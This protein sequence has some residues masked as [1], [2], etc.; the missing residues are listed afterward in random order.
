MNP[1]PD[2][3]WNPKQMTNTD[4]SQAISLIESARR[5]L[6]TTHIRPD[7]D[8]VGSIAALKTIIEQAAGQKQNDCV[9]QLL[10][11]S[12]PSDNYM[13]LLPDETWFLGEHITQEQINAG[14][15]ARFDLIIIAD[16]CAARQLQGL[17]NYLTQR[18]KNARETDASILVIDH[19]LSG[20]AIG[21]CQLVDTDA[22]A[23][24]EIIYRL[25]RRAD[26][27]LNESAASALLAAIGTDTGW[28]QF[29]NS[30]AQAFKIAG[31]LLEAGAKADRIYQKLYQNDPPEKL[32]LLAMTLQTLELYCDGRLAVMQITREML[33]KS[34]A[35]RS[36]IE[37]IVNEPQNIASVIAV[38]LLVAQDDGSTRGSLRSK[39]KVDVN[40]VARQFGGG[41]HARAAGLTIQ[42]PL[43]IARKRIIDA[44]IAAMS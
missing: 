35:K 38:I 20:D 14:Q 2:D 41:G 28:F 13:F 25:C 42:D 37:N 32:Q 5:I 17:S 16:T 1:Q 44:M 4:F 19:H 29:E 40:M 12:E 24:G 33:A 27:P 3:C 10:L 7:G 18:T 9:V 22:C 6:I 31:E 21:N 34:R 11:L 8:A 39:E 30:S 43:P 36:H 26:W 15:L 23:A